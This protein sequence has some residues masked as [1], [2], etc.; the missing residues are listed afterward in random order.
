[1]STTIFVIRKV[2]MK[3][4]LGRPKVP[5]SKLR[6]ILIQAR[7][8]P[9]EHSVIADAIRRSKEDTSKWVRKA[10]LFVAKGEKTA[11]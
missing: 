7:V 8:S 11:A 1:M 4:K 9:E 3:K 5:K 10:L 2:F 6:G